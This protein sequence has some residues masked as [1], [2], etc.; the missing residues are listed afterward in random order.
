MDVIRRKL[1]LKNVQEVLTRLTLFSIPCAGHGRVVSRHTSMQ[2]TVIL[3]DTTFLLFL[4]LS[5]LSEHASLDR[6]GATDDQ[7]SPTLPPSALPPCA[8]LLPA[9]CH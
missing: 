6:P 9:L 7:V 5:G 8:L 2:L 4:F 1:G 3:T